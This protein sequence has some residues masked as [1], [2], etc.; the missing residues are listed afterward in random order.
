MGNV[1][2]LW[3]THFYKELSFILSRICGWADGKC[4]WGVSFPRRKSTLSPT[5]LGALSCQ[6]SSFGLNFWIND[7]ADT[8]TDGLGHES[9]ILLSPKL[10]ATGSCFALYMNDID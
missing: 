5:F 7:E 8:Q 2:D 9:Q 10:Y 6:L 4:G 1:D 3:P